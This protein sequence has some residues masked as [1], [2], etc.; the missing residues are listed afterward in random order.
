MLIEQN[1]YSINWK[2]FK[3]GYSFFVPCLD[4]S[5]AKK[6]VIRVAK[7]LKMEVLIKIVIE[8]GVKGLRVWRI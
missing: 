6:E 1:S 5:A 7:R 3:S 2:N 4:T 8:D